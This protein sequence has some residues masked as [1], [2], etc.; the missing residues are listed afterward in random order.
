MRNSNYFALNRIS[1]NIILIDGISRTG[2]LLL[3]SLISSFEKM[4]HLEFG[5][6]FE[7]ILPATKF[8]KV[9]IDFAQAYLNNYLNQTIYNKYISRNVNFRPNDRTGIDKSKNPKIYYDRLKL[10]E[11]DQVIKLIKKQKNYLPFITHDLA[12]NLDILK[13][14]RMNFKII[15]IIRNPIDTVYSWYKRGLGDRYGSDQRMFTLLMKKKNIVYPWYNS[16]NG[17]S[18]KNYNSCERCV[19]HVINLNKNSNRNLR[20]NNLNKKTL[21]ITYEELIK[22]TLSEL[23][24]ISN[25]LGTKTNLKTIEFIKRENLPVVKNTTNQ[26]D[27]DKK[28][29]LIKKKCSKDLFKKL[30]KLNKEYE[31]NHYNLNVFK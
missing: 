31:N 20:N 23:K 8:K 6:N 27:F 18:D 4:E 7:H 2:K 30:I 24:R 10:D 19:E 22:N 12:I 15:E 28:I 13:K 11:G 1:K 16:L 25:F 26:K 5:E 3:G 17:Y 21:V 29:N 9:S 14:L